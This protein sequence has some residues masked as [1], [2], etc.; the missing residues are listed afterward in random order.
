MVLPERDAG[1]NGQGVQ[2]SF[3]EHLEGFVDRLMREVYRLLGSAEW[4]AH[5]ILS[6]E[7]VRAYGFKECFEGVAES[8]LDIWDE[9]YFKLGGEVDTG[10]RGSGLATA[11]G[12][13]E[14]CGGRF[15][16]RKG[17]FAGN[18]HA[19]VQAKQLW[20][21]AGLLVLVFL[22]WGIYSYA[23]M[24]A[25]D[26]ELAYLEEA[27]AQV[28]RDSLPGVSEEMAT[29]QYRS[30]LSSRMAMLT[31]EQVDGDTVSVSVIE[32]LRAISSV[33]D[34]KIHVEFFSLSLDGKRIGLQGET[35]SMNEVEGVRK[36][37]EK[38]K[39]FE[40]V[41]IKNAIAEKR[42]KKIRFEIEVTR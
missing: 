18:T 22:S 25:G 5:F 41:K 42:A 4:P 6:G 39:I 29:V 9:S 27:T 40:D 28:Y 20:Y 19:S 33:L 8:R 23:S 11:Y 14:D 13:A 35:R 38:T 31:G 1:E 15:N 3:R 12:I 34:R 36:A 37:F 26:R 24:I 21:A 10:Q 2:D 17:E 32:A 7:I 16:L 30:I